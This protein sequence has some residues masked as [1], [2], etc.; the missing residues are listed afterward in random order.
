[1]WPFRKK[2]PVQPDRWAFPDPGDTAVITLHRIIDARAPILSVWHNADDGSWQFLDGSNELNTDEAAVVALEVIV[3]LH[4]S[5]LEFAD[6]PKGWVAWRPNP[7]S[8]WKRRP[9]T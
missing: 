4:P 9:E 7:N 8:P 5:V 1:M 6:L 2:P 3:R